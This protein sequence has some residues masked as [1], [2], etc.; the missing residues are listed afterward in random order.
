MTVGELDKC[1]GGFSSPSKMPGLSFSLPALLTCPLG[2]K[3]VK[4]EGSVC[5]KCYALK[6]R[7]AFPVVREKMERRLHRM[8]ISLEYWAACISE[9]ISRYRGRRASFF[10]WHDSGD[11][12][13]L[14]HFQALIWVAWENPDVRF[15]L[16]TKELLTV[17]KMGADR[18]TLPKLPP[19]LVVRVSHPTIGKTLKISQVLP[20]RSSSVDAGEGW[21]CPAKSQGNQCGKCRACWDPTIPNVDYQLS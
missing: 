13:N 17:Q 8:R 7:Y 1:F 18:F 11:L 21:K 4:V 14:A 19:N 10:R 15:W 3:L 12:V 5:S 6:G 2:S 16:P 20:F 9:R